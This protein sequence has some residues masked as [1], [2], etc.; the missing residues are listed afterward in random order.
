MSLPFFDVCSPTGSNILGITNKNGLQNPYVHPCSSVFQG[1]MKQLEK[2]SI[3][4]RIMRY[5]SQWIQS[6]FGMV[7]MPI[8]LLKSANPHKKSRISIHPRNK[9]MNNSHAPKEEPSQ[10]LQNLKIPFNFHHFSQGSIQFSPF[11]CTFFPL[12]HD[13]N[14]GT[15]GIP[16]HDIDIRP[17]LQLRLCGPLDGGQRKG[18]RRFDHLNCLRDFVDKNFVSHQ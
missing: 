3:E 16:A 4:Y 15:R 18:H 2:H 6:I 1:K 12:F 11:F 13:Q 9:N 8:L 17:R 7:A 10:V 14:H 5:P